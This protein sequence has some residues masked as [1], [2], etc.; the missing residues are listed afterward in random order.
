MNTNVVTMD[1][2]PL[3][4][5]DDDIVSMSSR[6]PGLGP[7]HFEWGMFALALAGGSV[8]AGVALMVMGG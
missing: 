6:I 4:L 8:L 7:L 5:D 1:G 3:D 2:F